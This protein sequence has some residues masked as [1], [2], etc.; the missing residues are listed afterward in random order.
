MALILNDEQL[1]LQDAARDFLRERAPISHLRGLR[2]ENNEDRVSTG[3]WA[4]MAEMGWPAILVPEQHGGLDYGYSGLGIVLEEA[5]R[6]LTPSPLLST[7]LTGV[8][9]LRLAGSEAQCAEIFPG[10]VTG[11]K[12]L[13]LACD[14]T[15]RHDPGRV[16]TRADSKGEGFTLN[17]RKC[18][19][20]DGHIADTLIVSA[21]TDAGLSLLLV[22][23]DAEGVQVNRYPVLDIA[24][25]A[26]ISFDDVSLSAESLLGNAG[27]GQAVLD[28][29]L[30][31]SRIG[32]SAEML[33]IALEAFDRTM[34]YIK[35]RKQF[36]VPVGSFQGLQHRAAELYADIELC[37]SLIIKALQ[38]LDDSTA[39]AAP[40]ASATKAKLC[41]TAHAA[42]NE[43]IQMHGGI[44][45]TDEFDIG[46]FLKRCQI[47]ET[48]YGD[49]YF[50][51]DRFAKLNQ[52]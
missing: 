20:A 40:I 26:N 18:A 23:A 48:L 11:E 47:L 15:P 3:L 45:M 31:A 36:G 4:E 42:A 24:A 38:T 29:V 14:E 22:P 34:D 28:Q 51:L 2:D 6:T 10:V 9:A 49:R 30:D 13:A 8:A 5:G 21:M 27:G 12:K 37:K 46:F 19:V 44:G 52:Y 7:A 50:H 16:D 17:G 43:A 35:E 39:E 25:A 1:M 41:E 32:V 33:G